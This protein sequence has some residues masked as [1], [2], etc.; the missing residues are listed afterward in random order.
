[1]TYNSILPD[2]GNPDFYRETRIAT[3]TITERNFNPD[4]FDPG[5]D[6]LHR[7]ITN[8]D[9]GVIPGF[10]E[11]NHNAGAPRTDADTHTFTVVFDRD[12]K[13]TLDVQYKDLAGNKA[14]GR[15]NYFVIDKTYPVVSVSYDNNN[16]ING[17]YYANA[18]V[19]TITVREHNFAPDRVQI[20]GNATDNGAA[21]AFP[22][23]SAWSGSGDVHTATISYTSD[24]LYGF[25][26]DVTDAAG[27]ASADYTREEFYV[28]QTIPELTITN[29]ENLSANNDVVIPIITFSDTNYD[30][31]GVE[32]TLMGAN[33]GAVDPNGTYAESANGQTFTFA[34]FERVKEEDDLY[35]LSASI[36]DRAGNEYEDSISFSVNRFGSVYV[37]DSSL[38]SILN[39]YT[40]QAPEVV[41]R[42]I[43][44]DNLQPD[45]IQVKVAQNGTLRVLDQSAGDY[46]YRQLNNPGSWS[47]YEYTVPKTHFETDAKYEVAVYSV[48]AAG[49]INENV[50]AEK[51]AE[52]DFA[53]DKTNPVIVVPDL[54]SGGSYSDNTKTINVSIKD[55]LKLGDVRITL[56]DETVEYT[57]EGETYTYAI[58]SANTI[59]QTSIVAVDA[60]GN[61]T[62]FEADDFLVSSNIIV[63]WFFNRPL[64][65]GSIA[66]V[67]AG[68]ALM[69]ALVMRRRKQKSEAVAGS[70]GK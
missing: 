24:A 5:S 43:N 23:L 59:Q 35:T 60:A 10:N 9:S 3:V 22:G 56:N 6:D 48:D 44:V 12:G 62:I 17:N 15:N 50:A 45:S 65:I 28:D 41:F 13:Y 61:E 49:N 37:F 25:D 68:I 26:V 21:S 69:I 8:P 58:P 27:N 29:V 63:R 14:E 19:A 57:N 51:A 32:I 2:I 36:T 40:N 30:P 52:I 1:I 20:S 47:T 64:F 38:D 70:E 18:R 11:W 55:N 16:A 4:R 7:T 53:V 39:G 33:H 54:A 42:E 34:D 67:A 46:T 66:V 31:A